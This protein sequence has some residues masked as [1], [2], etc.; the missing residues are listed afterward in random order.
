M[1]SEVHSG[2]KGPPITH[3]HYLIFGPFRFETTEARLWCGAQLVPLRPRTG[4]VLQYLARH[5]RRVVTKT[6]LLEHVWAGMH[7]VDT[8]LRVCIREIRTALADTVDAPEYLQTVGRQGYQWLVMGDGDA[9]PLAAARPIVGRQAEV[10]TLE[11]QFGACRDRRPPARLPQWRRG[12]WQNNDPGPVVDPPGCRVDGVARAGEIAAQL[13]VHGER[14]GGHGHLHHPPGQP[15]PTLAYARSPR[16]SS[17]AEC[18][19]LLSLCPA[20]ELP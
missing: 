12:D 5:P 17:G 1:C 13:A 7:V 10:D 9:V 11:R 4:A 20:V 15:Q 2:G 8:V 16:S 19:L 14:G 18:A 6:E 3:E